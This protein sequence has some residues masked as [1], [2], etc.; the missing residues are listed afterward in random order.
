M[1]GS[2]SCKHLSC[3]TYSV[4]HSSSCQH[5]DPWWESYFSSFTRSLC[6]ELYFC[7]WRYYTTFLP[8]T[9]DVLLLRQSASMLCSVQI[10]MAHIL[11]CLDSVS[12][13]SFADQNFTETLTGLSTI[14]AY[15][16]QVGPP[17]G[18]S[19]SNINLVPEQIRQTCRRR[20]GP[21]ESSIFHDDL[22]LPLVFHKAGFHWEYSD[23]WHRTVCRGTSAPCR[24]SQN[25]CSAFIYAEQ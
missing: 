5:L 25:R 11:V 17:I 20:A 24:P 23:S 10:S 16:Q 4:F 18:I 15:G 22:D 12:F 9:T 21:G 8:C 6:L 19:I 13:K 2:L 1:D 14:R 3:V 7:P